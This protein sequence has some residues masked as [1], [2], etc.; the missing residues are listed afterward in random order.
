MVVES[1]MKDQR[2][3]SINPYF[4]REQGGCVYSYFFDMAVDGKMILDTLDDM[5]RSQ[6][7]GEFMQNSFDY[8]QKHEAEI[9]A[10]IRKAEG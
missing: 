8:C 4:P 2:L 6:S 10:H 7:I 3:S 1:V 9:R 5:Y